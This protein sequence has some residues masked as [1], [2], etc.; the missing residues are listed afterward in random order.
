MNS[1]ALARYDYPP[2]IGR[3]A[4]F[5]ICLFLLEQVIEVGLNLVL[6]DFASVVAIPN[7]HQCLLGCTL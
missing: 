5:E 3:A 6:L 4:I 2:H 1:D 7:R